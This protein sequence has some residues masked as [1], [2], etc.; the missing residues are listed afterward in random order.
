MSSL[1]TNMRWTFY[2]SYR[3]AHLKMKLLLTYVWCLATVVLATPPACAPG[4]GQGTRCSTRK[5]V[6]PTLE[7]SSSTT[8]AVSLVPLTSTPVSVGEIREVIVKWKTD[9]IF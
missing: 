1:V 9:E 7:Q 4:H 2:I 3:L 6:S 8:S 5:T